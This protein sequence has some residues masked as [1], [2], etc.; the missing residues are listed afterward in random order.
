MATRKVILMRRAASAIHA[1]R[2]LKRA[3]MH[4]TYDGGR[5]RRRRSGAEKNLLSTKYSEPLRHLVA[6]PNSID[7]RVID[8]VCRVR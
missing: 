1:L 4:Y 8:F 2:P 7:A 6:E 5:R 3:R